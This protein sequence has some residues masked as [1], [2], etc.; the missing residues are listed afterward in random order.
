MPG[1]AAGSMPIPVS[2]TV[3]CMHADARLAHAP[4]TPVRGLPMRG[5]HEP[6]WS[7]A[8]ALLIAHASSRAL[9]T[10]AA[11]D[12]RRPRGNAWERVSASVQRVLAGRLL[13]CTCATACVLALSPAEGRRRRRRRRTHLFPHVMRR[14]MHAAR[15]GVCRPG[16]PTAAGRVQHSLPLSGVVGRCPHP[17]RHRACSGKLERIA[18]VKEAGRWCDRCRPGIR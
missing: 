18:C 9:P 1:K 13:R 4:P 16:S 6:D 2:A 11:W 3:M 8:R 5:S 7:C 17:D 10:L 12:G 15:T 14:S